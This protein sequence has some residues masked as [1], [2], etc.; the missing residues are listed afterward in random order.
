MPSS[1]S[2]SSSNASDSSILPT[3][4]ELSSIL[5]DDPMVT[6]LNEVFDDDPTARHCFRY[7]GFL[8]TS[9]DRMQQ[10]LYRH[11]EELREIFDYIMTD[12]QIRTCLQPITIAHRR[13]TRRNRSHPYTRRPSTSSPSSS[14]NT[15]AQ[16]RNSPSQSSSSTEALLAYYSNN[17]PGTSVDDPIDLTAI[18]EDEERAQ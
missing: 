5:Q 14:S 9:I 17:L 8:T 11:E 7:F 16:Q 6:I 1:S 12:R 2:S 10:E 13:L 4:T 18:E 15:E 3:S